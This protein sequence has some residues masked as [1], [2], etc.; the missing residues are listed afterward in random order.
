MRNQRW[1]RLCVLVALLVGVLG[2]A[3][4]LRNL[5]D[6]A[7]AAPSGF[8]EAKFDDPALAPSA[9]A[10]DL[11][12]LARRTADELAQAYPDD[13]GTW[14]V[15]ARRHYLLSQTQ[16]ASELWRKSLA[17]DPDFAEAFFGLGLVALDN[18]EHEKAVERFE[19]VARLAPEDPR[20]PVLLAKSLMLAGRTDDAI[21]VIEKHITTEQTSAEAWEMAGKAHLQAQDFARAKAAFEVAVEVVPD[22]KEALY[23]LSRAYA[24][25]G[26]SAKAAEYAEKFRQLA[27]T[28]HAESAQSAK[29]FEDRDFAAHVA[30]Q[31][32]ADAARVYARHG[33][34]QRAEDLLL[35]AVRL[36]P[37][38]VEFLAQLQQSLQQRG[39][40]AHAAEVGERIVALAPG[41]IDHWLN[42]GWLY[43][44]V[45]Q[46]EKAIAA[47]RK[48]IEL[49]PHDPR[50]RQAYEI[51]QRFQ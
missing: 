51:I 26:E 43:S 34:V 3:F 6:G 39:A 13:P 11:L 38:S 15:Q 1:A 29:L 37:T 7:G 32:H 14:S 33:N 44:H 12:A 17:L 19:D 28:A 40:Q 42:L 18:D 45:N 30:A 5:R 2:F 16:E 21:L 8:L 47:C 36:E 24:G 9:S 48:A 23:G 49:N 50:C 27:E 22:M 4:Y 10:D 46:P 20:A 31:A 25:L 41:Q 35:R